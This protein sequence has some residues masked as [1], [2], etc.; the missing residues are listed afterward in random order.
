MRIDYHND[1]QAK[2]LIQ[3][4]KNI[5]IMPSKSGGLD[6]FSAAVGLYELLVAQD[7][8]CKILYPGK[9]PEGAD[10]IT[11]ENAVIS[12]FTARE[13]TVSIDFSGMHEAKAHYD[14]DGDTL[15]LK[16]G[17]VSK[18]F[19]PELRVRSK[20]HM[21]FDYDL[22]ITIGA[23]ELEDFGYVYDELSYEFTKTTILNIDNSNKNTRYGSV[24]IIDPQAES[25]TLLIL[26]KAPFWELELNK[27]A[28]HILLSSISQ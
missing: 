28:A 6:C 24:N 12:S 5:A 10:D 22:I 18:D 17:P 26:R 11:D 23:W 9:F 16:L 4:A 19:D 8:S 21:G 1:E 20:L 15:N 27:K 13:L 14:V 25:L 2:N 3:N 7:K